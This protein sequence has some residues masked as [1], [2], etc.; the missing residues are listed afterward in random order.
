MKQIETCSESARDAEF[1]GAVQALHDEGERSPT[2]TDVEQRIIRERASE[3]FPGLGLLYRAGARL[4]VVDI[5]AETTATRQRLEDDGRL[6]SAEE[7]GLLAATCDR[8]PALLVRIPSEPL[9]EVA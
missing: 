2:M 4:Y 7:A 6:E 1:L 5:S 9:A 3:M 8:P